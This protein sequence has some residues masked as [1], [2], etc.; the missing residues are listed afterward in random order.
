MPCKG[1]R[2]AWRSPHPSTM[3]K[4]RMTRRMRTF[5]KVRAVARGLLRQ[6][7]AVGASI[8][9][10]GLTKNMTSSLK[11]CTYLAKIGEESKNTLDRGRVRKSGHMLR[12]TSTGCRGI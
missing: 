9:A 3:T 8:K 2:A 1:K 12:N 5:L 7:T 6:L 11:V 4:V 10:V